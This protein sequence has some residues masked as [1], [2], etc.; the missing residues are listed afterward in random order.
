MSGEVIPRPGSLGGEAPRSG[1]ARAIHTAGRTS[2]AACGSRAE[3]SS[4]CVGL[5]S[6]GQG[7]ALLLDAA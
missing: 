4:W 2:K 7:G 6:C 5:M 1:Q 3:R